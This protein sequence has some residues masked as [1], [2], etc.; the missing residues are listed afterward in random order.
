[1]TN[2]VKLHCK[3]ID[4]LAEWLASFDV[5]EGPWYKWFEQKYCKKCEADAG[6]GDVPCEECGDCIY[7]GTADIIKLWLMA[8]YVEDSS[9]EVKRET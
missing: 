2:F 3:T 1:M 8:E 5:G 9:H 6:E 7:C 4:A